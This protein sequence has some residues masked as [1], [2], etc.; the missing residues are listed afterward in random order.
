MIATVEYVSLLD[1]ADRLASM[2]IRSDAY[3]RF[4]S[5][6]QAVEDSRP[7]QT[8]ITRFRRIR[9]RYNEVQRFGRYHPDYHTVTREMMETKRRMDVYPL[10]A[11]MRRAEKELND[12]LD[13]ISLKLARSVSRSIKVPTGDPFFDRA[14]S[15]GCGAGGKCKCRTG[16]H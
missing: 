1:E 10:I 7:A 2:I 6:R 16:I 14:C 12:M 13:R 15:A 11:E 8:L 5:C 3:V 9:E 4:C